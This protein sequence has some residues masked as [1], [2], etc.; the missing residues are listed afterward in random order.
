MKILQILPEMNVGGVERGTLDLSKYMAAN[1]HQSV[2][3]SNGGTLVPALEA[4]GARH[5]TLP[6][7]RKNLWTIYESIWALEKI[8]RA[9]KVDIVHA[10]SRV[11]ALIAYFACRRTGVDFLTTC[12]G[13]YSRN[14]FSHVMGWGKL[15]IVIS[16]IIGR[17][18]IE[19]FGVQPQNIRLIHRSVDLDKFHFRA[20]LP[21]QSS[22]MVTI[23]GRITPLKGHT[24]F[25]KAMA[26]VMRQ[27]PYVR[28][29]IIGD[30]PAHKQAYKESLL[31][32]AR[33]LGIQDKVEFMGNRSDIPSLLAESDALVLSTVTQEAFGRVII[34]AQAVGVPVV[35]TKVGGVV[36]I[37]EHE[38][39]GLL[40]LPEDADALAAAVLRLIN[41]RKLAD[42][43]CLEA[44]RMVEGKYTLG[45]MAIKT[46]AVYDELKHS[47][48]IL[49]IKLSAVGDVILATASL[50]A[51][52]EA[53][54]R[55]RI[56][57]L[58][59]R[60]SA[61]VLHHCPY[62]DDVIVYD[63][64]QKD[65]G[66]LG[67]WRLIVRLRKFRFDKVIDLQNNVRTHLAA[68]LCMPRASYGYRNKKFGGL[69]SHGI[70]DDKPP[71]PPVQHQFDVLKEV[72][73]SF[74]DRIRL[75]LWPRSDD[76]AY[77]RELLQ[78]EWIDEKTH[79]IIGINIASSSRW[80]TKNWPAKAIA[81]L[82][83]LLAAENIRVIIT[84]M[85]KDKSLAREIAARAKSRP[86]IIVGKTT[87]LQ[88]SALIGYCHVYVTS[89]SAPLH[90]AAA[91]RVPVVA[92]F[93]P[94]DPQRH[95]PPG[96]NIS[97]MRKP[98]ACSPCYRTTCKLTTH[99]CMKDITA[100]EVYA[101]I[102]KKLK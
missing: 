65:R 7:H 5:Y 59:G 9:E 93:G 49:V 96:D 40:V 48:N 99:A 69:L 37:V 52:R 63:H 39:T 33:R 61:V 24:F 87:I 35:A 46:L 98:M 60:E 45:Q 89:D 16:E 42:T 88:L 1:G 27:L 92:L 44:R 75:E 66:V 21:G 18:M 23:V 13:Y 85:D 53:F 58:T 101:E 32:L 95:I 8:I 54:P 10:R 2:V 74:N 51:L 81:E 102:K 28:A 82:C 4:Q 29:R 57:C 30:A 17:H 86:G 78:G 72:G 31:L 56:C 36:D 73:I 3:V 20:R 100:A 34:E 76:A 71:M 12:H 84:G 19:H 68:F 80:A 79:R 62:I 6:V 67:F 14:I 41:D 25:L 91:M 43:M 47:L 90:I 70:A 64:Q 94:T 38:K 26:R 55:A 15:V 83:D 97:V 11:P 50:K 22:F 77:A